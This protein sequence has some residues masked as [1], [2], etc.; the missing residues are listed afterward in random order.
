MQEEAAAGSERGGEAA[1]ETPVVSSSRWPLASPLEDGVGVLKGGELG[2]R[3][4]LSRRA[5]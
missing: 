4:L 1:S 3:E 5:R 2:E